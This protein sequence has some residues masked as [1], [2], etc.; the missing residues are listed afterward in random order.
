M[1]YHI[2]ERNHLK[3][4]PSYVYVYM[5]FS[6]L[7][8][9]AQQVITKVALLNAA[10]HG[11][12]ART[13][14]V[15]AGF[16][17]DFPEYKKEMGS[18]GKEI[19]NHVQEINALPEQEQREKLLEIDPS[20]LDKKEPNT[21][22]LKEVD[23][24]EGTKVVTAFPPGPEKYP[25]IGH[26]KAI[27]MNYELSQRYNGEFILRFEDTNPSTVKTEYYEAMK[28]DFA[29]L[30]VDWDEL[31]YASDHMDLYYT[32]VSQ[33]IKEGKAYVATESSQ[34]ISE[35]RRNKEPLESR[36]Q[37]V[38]E[39]EAIW[40]AMMRGENT[41]DVV[42]LKADITH[43]NSAMRDPTL[44][45]TLKETHARQGDK[46]SLWPTYD[47]QTTVLDG[48]YGVTHRIR[49]KE[50]E[51]RNELHAYMQRVLGYDVTKIYEFARFNVEGAVISG[52]KIRDGIESGRYDGWDDPSLM[53]LSALRRRGFHPGAIK[54]YVM[55]TGMSK[56]ESTHSTLELEQANYKY[57]KDAPS[58][59]FMQ[60]PLRVE[61]DLGTVLVHEQ[62]SHEL[63]EGKAYRTRD[64][65]VFS[66]TAE[67]FTR[68]FDT[69]SYEELDA[70]LED[71]M[72]HVE[73]LK[74]DTTISGYI[75]FDESAETGQVIKLE[76]AGFA[77]IDDMDENKL[78]FAH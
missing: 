47:L 24:R 14:P 13:G 27:L 73:V 40:Q 18:L 32:K 55:K 16:L 60:T 46:Y 28:E 76:G 54:Q 59:V 44:M 23:I 75:L 49:S 25:H 62:Q 1:P 3:T 5:K 9:E 33:L 64:G 43:K 8:S 19:T 52:R 26:A 30:G 61:S 6:D 50:F 65:K 53:T 57:V 21:D 70:A 4:L 7:P 35:S 72:R 69:E 11:G 34:E 2:G 17:G 15:I 58:T 38:E 48:E 78:C 42:L 66:Y 31:V 68:D 12:E 67:G 56:T 45:R 37:S 39:N 36:N 71:N 51:L 41:E 63:Q 20:A 77:R 74:T 10:Q 29:W 22:P